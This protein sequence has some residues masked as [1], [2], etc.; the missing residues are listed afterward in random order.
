VPVAII[1]ASRDEIVPAERTAGLR[2][3]V[4][5]LVFDKTIERSGHND[6]YARSEFH[7]A[8]REALDRFKL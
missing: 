5:N 7:D 3:Q 4:A 2:E 1:A 6:I 8:M